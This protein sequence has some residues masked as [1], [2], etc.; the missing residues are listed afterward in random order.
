MAR[1]EK[2]FR[3]QP[4]SADRDKIEELVTATGFF[5]SEEIA[6]AVELLEER[7]QKGPASGYDFILLEEN[8]RLLGYACFGPIPG[9]V[10]SYDLYWIAVRPEQQRLGLG[11]ELLARCEATIRQ[12]GGRRLYIDTSGRPRYAATHSFYARCGYRREAVLPD[13]YAPG[14]FKIIFCKELV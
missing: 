14:D 6:I 11:G 4:C 10:G 12:A 7:L 2:R 3:T 5:S 9:A 8:S 1:S 13:F